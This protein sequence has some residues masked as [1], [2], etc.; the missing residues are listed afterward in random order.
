MSILTDIVRHKKKEIAGL[1]NKKPL[2]ALKE[3]AVMQPFKKSRFLDALRKKKPV[4][5]IAEIKKKSPSKGVLRKNF[6]PAK[7]AQAYQKGG[8][9]A[10]S[11]LT[12]RKFF[13]GSNENLLAARKAVKLPIL[14]KD[15]IIDEYQIWEAKAIGADAILLIASILK[16]SVMR[17]FYA[18][19]QRLG[20][21]VLFEIHSRAEL[22]KIEPLKPKL[23]GINNRNLKTFSVDLSVTRELAP[24][25]KNKAFIVSESGIHSHLDLLMLKGFNA[26]AVLV[27]ESLMREKN[28]TQALKR[29]LGK[30]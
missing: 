18:L 9:A 24:L 16:A 2:K 23:I 15:F 5:V 21:D 1:K 29:L 17:K 11:V 12:D 20:L 6:N 7:I 4:A 14:R 22:K 26:K 8:A 27:G 13:D 19:A 30:A 10:L 25:I 28:V 3:E